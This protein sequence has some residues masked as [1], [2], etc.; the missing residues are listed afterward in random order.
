MRKFPFICLVAFIVFYP[1]VSMPN[2]L[3]AAET[4]TNLPENKEASSEA[5]PKDPDDT[6]FVVSTDDESAAESLNRVSGEIERGI[7]SPEQTYKSS[8]HT[9]LGALQRSEAK[10]AETASHSY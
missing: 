1:A 7:S 5:S 6:L 3:S 10:S 4:K 8:N 9:K 2:A